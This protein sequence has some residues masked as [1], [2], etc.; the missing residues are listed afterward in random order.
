MHTLASVRSGDSTAFCKAGQSQAGEKSLKIWVAER[1]A[2]RCS[3]PV[4]LVGK[5]SPDV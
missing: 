2:L 3:V 4:G 5:N 1:K